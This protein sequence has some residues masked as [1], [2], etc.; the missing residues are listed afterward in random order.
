MWDLMLFKNKP[1]NFSTKSQQE[2][3]LLKL[4]AMANFPRLNKLKWQLCIVLVW[5]PH[6][7][8]AGHYMPSLPMN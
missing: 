4:K 8:T 5:I 6:G 7:G 2:E 3:F 1:G